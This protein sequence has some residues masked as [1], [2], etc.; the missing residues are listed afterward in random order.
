[1]AQAAIPLMIASAAFSAVGSMAAG[2]QN[3][4]MLNARAA[5][6]RRQGV[7]ERSEIRRASREAMGRQIMAA[8]ESGFAPN[9]GTARL[10]LEESLIN[11]ELDIMTSKRNAS[12]RAAGLEQQ[13][14]YAAREGVFGAVGA[15]L[16]GASQ[17]AG[18][19]AGMRGAG[20]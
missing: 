19:K 12:A 18:Y 13:G 15:L 8:A 11:R 20:A 17:V 5:E 9:T 3:K 14:K 2:Q 7:A 1:M 4:A 6:E 10:E 16:N